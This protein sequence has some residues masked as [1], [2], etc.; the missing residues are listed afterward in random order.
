[1]SI[2]NQ[3]ERWNTKIAVARQG[4]NHLVKKPTEG[5]N[6]SI[7]PLKNNILEN[8]GC[9]FKYRLTS[10]KTQNSIGNA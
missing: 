4:S 10:D 7:V 2:I 1:M 6:C 9:A 3:L 8:D 5:I